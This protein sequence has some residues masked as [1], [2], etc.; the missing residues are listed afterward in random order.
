MKKAKSQNGVDGKEKRAC[1]NKVEIHRGK[2]REGK[3]KQR[4]TVG[5]LH[6]RSWRSQIF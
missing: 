5:T 2:V 4:L 3:R 1:A 6:L